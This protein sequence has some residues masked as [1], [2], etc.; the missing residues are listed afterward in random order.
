MNH[1]NPRILKVYPNHLDIS[2]FLSILIIFEPK[3]F[4]PYLSK[5]ISLGSH[6]LFPHNPKVIGNYIYKS[7]KP[8]WAILFSSDLQPMITVFEVLKN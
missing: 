3:T 4:Y 1:S 5:F 6:H 7:F 2:K 8:Q